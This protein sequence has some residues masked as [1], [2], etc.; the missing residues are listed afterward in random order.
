MPSFDMEDMFRRFTAEKKKTPENEDLF[1]RI[2]LNREVYQTS[3]FIHPSEHRSRVKCGL[4]DHRGSGYRITGFQ[5]RS[6]VC[7]DCIVFLGEY[8]LIKEKLNE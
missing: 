4:C 7:A 5:V 3:V 2:V 1:A 6:W 8:E